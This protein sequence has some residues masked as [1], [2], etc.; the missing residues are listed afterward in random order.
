MKR[1]GL[2]LAVMLVIVV[3][4]VALSGVWFNR[5]GAPD[6]VVTLTE[7]ELLLMPS[8]DDDSGIALRLSW[9]SEDPEE[10]WDNPWL[11]RDKLEELGFN[12]PPADID[13]N[14]SQHRQLFVVLEYRE[15]EIEPV[16]ASRL[17]AVDAGRDPEELRRLYP[18][19]ARYII[20]PADVRLRYLHDAPEG[21]KLAGR[22]QRLLPPLIHVPRNHR[23]LFTGV[24]GEPSYRVT[25][26]YGRRHEPWILAVE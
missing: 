17:S 1:T 5:T 14:V 24:E 12:C 13:H 10:R 26:R 21:E 2:L 4:L 18:D 7:R 8:E 16:E 3:N 25:L 19:R 11:D 22:V 15:E 9:S 23:A 6:A 20:T